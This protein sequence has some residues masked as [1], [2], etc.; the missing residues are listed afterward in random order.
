MPGSAS[1]AV[2]IPDSV[3]DGPLRT[4]L[5]W[6]AELRRRANTP[7]LSSVAVK[8]KLKGQPLSTATVRRLLRGETLS[9][10]PAAA[11]AYTLAEMDQRPLTDRPSNDWD[12]FDA[13]LTARLAA[14][15][16]GDGVAGAS[17]P[18]AGGQSESDA[19]H[20]SDRQMDGMPA[21]DEGWTEWTG[22]LRAAAGSP[23]LV[24]IA[25][26]VAKA[27]SEQPSRE[28]VRQSLHGGGG[29]VQAGAV[30]RVL[31]L[32]SVYSAGLEPSSDLVWKF[33]RAAQRLF[34]Q[35]NQT[36]WDVKRAA[37]KPSEMWEDYLE[38][39]RE[40]AGSPATQEIAEHVEAMSEGIFLPERVEAL[41]AAEGDPRR[42]AGDAQLVVAALADL[43]ARRGG[44]RL[45]D[46]E[47]AILRLR[48]LALL[49]QRRP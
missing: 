23:T 9:E 1:R 26:M 48:T 46:R 29:V 5:E 37:P 44:Y 34:V 31:A 41:L 39:L 24:R 14:A 16:A 49:D 4:W 19:Q 28:A 22:R 25:E 30:A 20:V 40:E 13:L 8:A 17:G 33:E 3:P 35:W 10:R 15:I 47:Q 45:N 27:W 42:I 38:R 12:A 36:N 2:E 21:D 32:W 11:L 18:A 43:Q 7:S 6:L